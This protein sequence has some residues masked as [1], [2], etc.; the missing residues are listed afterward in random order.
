MSLI[1]ENTRRNGHTYKR[2]HGN[3]K[4]NQKF[5]KQRFS[6]YRHDM[7]KYV[8]KHY[9][10]ANA[11]CSK[12]GRKRAFCQ[13]PK[14]TIYGCK[15]EIKIVLEKEMIKSKGKVIVGKFGYLRYNNK[16]SSYPN[17]VRENWVINGLKHRTRMLS[18][19]F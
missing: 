15:S 11:P 16:T 10:E 2:F 8:Q 17:W 19:H 1:K 12:S 5:N 14:D 7:K 13:S 6:S 3:D 18:Y 4:S 9:D